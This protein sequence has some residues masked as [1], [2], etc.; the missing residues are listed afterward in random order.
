[1][2]ISRHRFR[3]TGAA[4]APMAHLDRRLRD[5]RSDEE[6]AA[7]VMVLFFSVMLLTVVGI[8]A[9]VMRHEMERARLQAT[10]DSAV[11]AGAGSRSDTDPET[12]VRDYFTKSGMSGYLNDFDEDDIQTSLTSTRV[13]ASAAMNMNTYLMKLA[14]VDNLT[15]TAAATAE[16]RVPKLEVAMVLDVSGS[17]GSN[18]KLP[19]LQTA[20]KNFV[21]TILNNST[22][23]DTTI[24]IVPF[25][26]GVTPSDGIYNALNVNETHNYSTC[27]RLDGSDYTTTRMDTAT[28]YDQQIFTSLYGTFQNLND[29]WR[30]CYT[31]DYFRVMAYS[32]SESDLHTKIDS[33][34]AD[35]N[36]SSHQGMKWGAALLDPAFR[37]VS[38]AL[39]ANGEVDASLAS[40]PADFTQPDTLKIV[41]MMGDGQNT[42][43]YYFNE[44][45]AYRGPDS[46]LHLVR[47]TQQT[48]SYA[49]YIYN[50]SYRSYDPSVCSQWWWECVYEADGEEVS[51]HYLHDRFDNRYWDFENSR[52][53][54]ETTFNNLPNSLSG[55]ISSEALDWETTWGMI[56]P[57][58]FG[59]LTGHWGPWNDYVGSEREDG[60]IKDT[61]MQAICSATKNQG[62]V[63]Y[64][65]GFEISRGGNA[66]TQ[67]RNCA[68][69]FS[70]YFRAEGVNI[71]D[72][73]SA[74]AS[75]VQHLR[76]TQ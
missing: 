11:L 8:G 32:M 68:S 49:Y 58:E 60:S 44:N 16:K 57:R 33:L 75:N 23:G 51:A 30:S 24:S 38:A 10:L 22:P 59:D 13:S 20:A 17:M 65:I 27:L 73:F 71:S 69:S 39:I 7:A 55:F 25:S 62:V 43:S 26:W 34:Q 47:Y 42:T 5:F 54:S 63:V 19:N 45:S 53:I 12:V 40:V 76:L 31:D 66:E 29:S 9:D 14:G 48:F 35:G 61:R 21:T 72:A 50:A 28:A 52:W 56:S 74:I 4:G 67:L 41:V 37:D 15:A 2:T 3:R 18:N 6:G 1:M 70:H 64:T 46:D 36:T